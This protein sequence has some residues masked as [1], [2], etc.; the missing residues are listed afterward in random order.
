MTLFLTLSPTADDTIRTSLRKEIRLALDNHK[1]LLYNEGMLLSLT[2][3]VDASPT[4]IFQVSLLTL[5]C[6]EQ[7][8]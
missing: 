8:Y 4:F 5:L 6:L 7:A 3:S 1:A 2:S